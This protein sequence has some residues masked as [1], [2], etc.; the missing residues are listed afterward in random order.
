MS[1]CLTATV[2]ATATSVPL[3]LY[4]LEKIQFSQKKNS[5]SFNFSF[6]FLLPFIGKILFLAVFFSLKFLIQF[7]WLWL[8]LPL[9]QI[10][11]IQ[12]KLLVWFDLICDSIFTVAKVCEH[13]VVITFIGAIFFTTAQRW[14]YGGVDD[15]ICVTRLLDSLTVAPR[16]VSV[17]VLV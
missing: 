2:Q 1:M 13:D 7:L 10:H 4:F 8:C 11:V 5:V 12:I 17:N 3:P 14:R 9:Y 16:W 15:G 6:I